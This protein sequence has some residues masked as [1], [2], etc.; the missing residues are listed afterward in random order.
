MQPLPA[1]PAPSINAFPAAPPSSSLPT[2][3]EPPSSLG[4]PAGLEEKRGIHRQTGAGMEDEKRGEG[5]KDPATRQHGSDADPTLS[6]AGTTRSEHLDTAVVGTLSPSGATPNPSKTARSATRSTSSDNDSVLSSLPSSPGAEEEEEEQEQEEDE[7]EDEDEREDEGDDEG[8]EEEAE[9]EE[10]DGGRPEG[11]DPEDD[12]DDDD[13]DKQG[14]ETASTR[15]RLN[16][17]NAMHARKPKSSQQR[18][19]ARAGQDSQTHV[20]NDARARAGAG[21]GESD[22]SSDA[23]TEPLPPSSTLSK[24]H[25]ASARNLSPSSRFKQSTS[26]TES[27]SAKERRAPDST[28]DNL[29]KTKQHRSQTRN[30]ITSDG[31]S[32]S[33]GSGSEDATRSSSKAAGISSKPKSAA[34]RRKRRVASTPSIDNSSVSGSNS[35]G[36]AVVKMELDEA[37]M[38]AAGGQS[39]LSGRRQSGKG[40]YTQLP[41][42]VIR[43]R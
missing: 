32:E 18:Q 11:R 2:P 41:S 19:P 20:Y 5:G 25:S 28:G 7:G 17:A 15:R 10:S 37:D 36:D 16:L 14:V 33:D 43:C 22:A 12:D 38:Q 4:S 31:L 21:S 9:V 26:T 27:R 8:D 1:V 24:S 35:D 30:N 3:G 23:E 42:C 6:N 39:G 29:N 34:A 13:D 40:E